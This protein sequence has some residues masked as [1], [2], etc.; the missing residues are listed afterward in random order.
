MPAQGF[1]DAAY[2]QETGEVFALLLTI[3][4]D[5]L[6]APILLTDAGEDIVYGSNVLDASGNI[7]ALAGTYVNMPIA[8][9]PPGQSDEQQSGRITIPNIDQ[10]IG[11]AIDSIASPASITITAV[12]FSDPT[13]VLASHLM[14]ELVNVRGDALIVE[15]EV[16]RPSLTVEPYPK[17][18]LRP[19]VFR[20]AFRMSS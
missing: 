19:S 3:E 15:G 10:R 2:P 6:P 14:L 9:T 13:T 8:I 20:A 5:D 1:R 11:E 17:D 7:A 16:N 4:H 18:W 12:L